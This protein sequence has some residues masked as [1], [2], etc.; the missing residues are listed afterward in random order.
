MGGRWSPAGAPRR[1]PFPSTFTNWTGEN[2]QD[3]QVPFAK[4]L[5]VSE[6]LIKKWNGAGNG[7]VK[8]AV[9]FPTYTQVT[10]PATGAA[11]QEWKDQAR[12]ARELGLSRQG[13]LKMMARLSLLE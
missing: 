5:E 13:L 2:S 11:L 10:N 8:M 4:Q 7:R 1:G 12:A 6:A 3:V 9:V